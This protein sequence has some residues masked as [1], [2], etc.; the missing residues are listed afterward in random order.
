MIKAADALVGVG[1]RVRVVST[2]HLSWMEPFDL[3]VHRS[4]RW[5]WSVVDYSRSNVP[6][7]YLWSGSRMRITR[8]IASVLGPARCPTL[9]A[10]RAHGR[11]HPELM[12]TILA[13]PAELFYGGTTGALAA[14]AE[15]GRRSG[16]P[17][18]LDL[19]DFHSA[20][21]ADGPAGRLADALAERIERVV[22][23]GA[24]FLTAASPAIAAAYVDKYNVHPIPIHNALPLP[25]KSPDPEPSSGDGLRLYWFSQTVG[26]GRGLEDAVRAMGFGAIPGELHLR[27]RA[28]PEYLESL[29][30][31]A[32]EAAPGLKVI[33]HEP[34]C[35][36]RMVALCRGL[37]VG[38][39]L[40]PGFSLNNRL[41]LSNKLFTYLLAGLAVAISDTPG[42]RLLGHTLGEAAILYRPGD[43]AAL[44]AGLK[45]WADDKRLLA[46]GRTLA[47]RAARQR[48][49]WEHPEERGALLRAVTG[50]L[51]R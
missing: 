12:S 40:E 49:H 23:P 35:P 43:V 10:A 14:V 15:A 22:L 7:I 33:H 8:L 47:W 39:A 34:A 3:A 30:R 50:M 38:L 25:A 1:Y 28:I 19:E 6:T 29:T 11:L 4:R 41:A 24:A 20:E 37:D 31:L 42:Q 27:G 26:P 13:E 45:R 18:A 21:Q 9:V 36:D 51:D 44:G 32:E 17:Y 16:I 46:R 48:W 2:H 5:S